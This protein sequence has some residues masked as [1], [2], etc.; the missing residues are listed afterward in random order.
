MPYGAIWIAWRAELTKIGGVWIVLKTRIRRDLYLRN[1]KWGLS[2]WTCPFA[3][4]VSF[5]PFYFVPILLWPNLLFCFLFCPI[6][7][8]TQSYFDQLCFEPPF[9][10]P[11]CCSICL[12]AA[13]LG[14]LCIEVAAANGSLQPMQP[15][16][17]ALPLLA[18]ATLAP[19]TLAPASSIC[20]L[21]APFFKSQL[22]TPGAPPISAACWLQ[23]C[24]VHCTHMHWTRC[25]VFIQSLLP[26]LPF[27]T[28]TPP[29]LRPTCSPAQ[30]TPNTQW[31]ANSALGWI[32]HCANSALLNS[33]SQMQSIQTSWPP[34]TQPF[35][36]PLQFWKGWGKNPQWFLFFIWAI[37][38]VSLT[39][40]LPLIQNY[41]DRDLEE[42]GNV[43]E[44]RVGG[45]CLKAWGTQQE[46]H[47]LLLQ[48]NVNQIWWLR[49]IP[50]MCPMSM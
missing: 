16:Q 8:L 10:D 29:Y 45:N 30:C 35:A 49:H 46:G 11:A 27:D 38:V 23:P 13:Y 6:W 34:L 3:L 2:F 43:P 37:K 41:H 33:A 4:V 48:C 9:F 20:S 40:W 39:F 36:C 47:A 21:I 15:I 25:K 7:P 24:P 44:R 22:H 31:Y 5:H 32:V 19:G 1:M 14:Q 12:L 42:K 26:L 50:K 28:S 17:S 18:P